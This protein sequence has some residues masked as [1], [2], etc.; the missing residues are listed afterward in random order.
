[1][2]GAATKEFGTHRI[3]KDEY[4][5]I[6]S[7]VRAAF[8]KYLIENKLIDKYSA[9]SDVPPL[10][11]KQDFGDIDLISN[12]E[13]SVFKDFLD[14]DVAKNY[15]ISVIGFKRN[16]NV[17][18]YALNF[19]DKVKVQVDYIYMPKETYNFAKNYFSY[20][21]LGNFIGKIAN[22]YGYKFGH[23]GLYKKIVVDAGNISNKSQLP[24]KEIRRHDILLT[25]DFM[26]ALEFLG[27]KK[28][29]KFNKG[30]TKEEM[31]SFVTECESFYPVIFDPNTPPKNSAHKSRQSKRNA[32]IDFHMFIINQP[33]YHHMEKHGVN[34]NKFFIEKVVKVRKSNLLVRERKMFPVLCNKERNIKKIIKTEV[35][36]KK[37]L[38][39]KLI[40]Q[41][42]NEYIQNH[43][44][45][46][47]IEFNELSGDDVRY[48]KIKIDEHLEA[49]KNSHPH[50]K[51]KTVANF[52]QGLTGKELDEVIWGE[53]KKFYQD[54]KN[55][56]ILPSS[57]N[58]KNPR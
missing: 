47:G 19:K 50:A 25:Q 33:F 9:F 43:A 38:N 15:G 52:T 57:E 45:V 56:N 32:H 14:S 6:Q 3:S 4:D 28:P 37:R 10:K 42:A 17:T 13:T 7:T 51:R 34:N 39:F 46:D 53:I 30:F 26:T 31:Y 22:A 35:F 24:S 58:L 21:D 2:G 8:S 44:K 40:K 41:L 16:S 20:G 27:F 55:K 12:I 49:L 29:F 36:F 48:L 1:M 54:F 11:D 18:S 23:D 5:D